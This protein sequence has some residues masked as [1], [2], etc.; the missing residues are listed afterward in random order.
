MPPHPPLFLK[1]LDPGG[2]QGGMG[3]CFQNAQFSEPNAVATDLTR[4]LLKKELLLN[5]LSHFNVKVDLYAVWKTSNQNIMQELK[6]T[7][8]EEMD[9]LVKWLGPESSKYTLSIQDFQSEQ[10]SS[11]FAKTLG[12][13]GRTG[14]AANKSIVGCA[15]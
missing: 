4:F 11:R 14:T 9:L 5:R 6:V 13:F 15:Q 3:H 7:S 2:I 10:S 1:V 12:S 8:F